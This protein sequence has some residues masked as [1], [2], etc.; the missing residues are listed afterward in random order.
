MSEKM[1][2]C[3]CEVHCNPSLFLFFYLWLVA[4][5]GKQALVRVTD[6][7]LHVLLLQIIRNKLNVLLTVHHNISVQQD[8]Q[9]ALY[10]FSLLHLISPTFFQTLF[11]HHQ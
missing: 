8:Q 4:R 7:V 3:K 10:A 5:A 11:A 6:N 9:Y 1:W 2:I